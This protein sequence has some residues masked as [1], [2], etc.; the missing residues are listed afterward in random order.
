[1]PVTISYL[2]QSAILSCEIADRTLAQI[3]DALDINSTTYCVEFHDGQVT[4]R[5]YTIE[6]LLTTRAKMLKVSGYP[7]RSDVTIRGK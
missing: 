1:M 7:Y 2:G 4:C 5:V 3:D 6:Q